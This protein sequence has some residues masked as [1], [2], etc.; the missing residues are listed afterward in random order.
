MFK[1]PFYCPTCNQMADAMADPIGLLFAGKG[2]TLECSECGTKY[3]ADISFGAVGQTIN[4]QGSLSPD[5]TK[6]D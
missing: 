5:D 1:L 4:L 3:N 6:E 2:F